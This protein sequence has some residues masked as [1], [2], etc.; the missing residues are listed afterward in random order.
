MLTIISKTGSKNMII[1]TRKLIKGG[2]IF[3]DTNH[4]SKQLMHDTEAAISK[5]V[6]QK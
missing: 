6:R 1:D 2:H 4:N 3:V 5:L